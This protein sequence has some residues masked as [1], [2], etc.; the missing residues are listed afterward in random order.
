[1]TYYTYDNRKLAYKYILWSLDISCGSL[2]IIFEYLE[3]MPS[4]MYT[5]KKN[6]EN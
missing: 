6:C 4:K 3:S 5:I 2:L 1:M